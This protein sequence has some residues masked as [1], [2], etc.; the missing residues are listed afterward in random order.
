M[1]R[2]IAALTVL[3][4]PAVAAAQETVDLGTL[5]NE[6]IVVV[7][8]LLYPKED[9]T[10]FSFGLGAIVF[11]PYM[12]APKVQLTGGKHL[13]ENLEVEGQLGV[14]Y[15]LGNGT[16]R[17]LG[18]AA[19]GIKPEVYRY[20]GSA[21]AGIAWAPI[22]AKMNFMGTRVIHHD[23]YFPLV[24][25][26]TLERQAWA[27]KYMAVSPTLGIGIGTRIFQANG[28]AVRIEL[29]DDLMVQNRKQTG[30]WAFKQNVGIVVGY[31][32]MSEAK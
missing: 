6:E 18:T 7:Q 30:V 21:T 29:R 17:E 13:T 12:I 5:R 28:G 23:L 16:Y 3:F 19:Y 22:Y 9:R 24:V 26:A 20:L 15:G 32:R 25:G 14:G 1:K 4:A 10:E 11:D 2:L 8:K 27:E 31:S